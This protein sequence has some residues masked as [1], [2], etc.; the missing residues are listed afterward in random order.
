MDTQGM[1][2]V[3]TFSGCDTAQ[4]LIAELNELKKQESFE[5]KVTIVPS[6]AEAEAMGLYGSPTIVINGIEYQKM[7]S[8]N[9]GFY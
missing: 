7:E 6:T 2:E 3:L 9:P 4:R 5:L 8:S 1:V